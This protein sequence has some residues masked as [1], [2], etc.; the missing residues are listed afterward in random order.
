[1][2]E[3]VIYSSSI[4][5]WKEVLKQGIK[6]SYSNTIGITDPYLTMEQSQDSLEWQDWPEVQYP[7]SYNYLKAAPSPY[8]MQEMK[9][10]KSLRV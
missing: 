4:M 8:T 6:R 10:Y 7:D 2:V 1:M 9:A 3:Q 5:I